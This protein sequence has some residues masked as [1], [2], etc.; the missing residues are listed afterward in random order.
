MLVVLAALGGCAASRA[1][2]RAPRGEECH[3]TVANRT[4]SPLAI[5]QFVG[6]GTTEIG[7]INPNESV[8]ATSPC[9]EGGAFIAGVPI[10]VQIGVSPSVP[11]LFASVELVPGER[12]RVNL[13]WP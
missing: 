10:P 4:G 2:A 1:S 6:P 13:F 8:S 3:F 7:A 9:A 5:R 12:T 11:P